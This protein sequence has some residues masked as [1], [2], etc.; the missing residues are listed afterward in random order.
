MVPCELA[1]QVTEALRIPT[2]GIGA[3]V[4]CDG[5]VLV[6]NDLLGLD[7]RFEPRFVRRFAQLEQPIVD[8]MASYVR[9]VREGSFPTEEHSFH[10]KRAS[11][12]IAR[13]Y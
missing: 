2:I 4:A 5:Q 3:G 13:L 8:A 10:R 7:S 6:C 12:K 9:A 11:R 1:E